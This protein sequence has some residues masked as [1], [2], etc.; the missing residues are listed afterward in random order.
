MVVVLGVRARLTEDE[1]LVGV[2][3]VC[4]DIVFIVRVRLTADSELIGVS[5]ECLGAMVAVMDE[6]IM[7]SLYGMDQSV[8][9]S[10]RTSKWT[11]DI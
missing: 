9:S 4:L 3:G 6:R 10:W 8:Q 5:R 1:L 2:S 11:V 7:M